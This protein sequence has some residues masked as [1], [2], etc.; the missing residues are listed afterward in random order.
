MG[1]ASSVSGYFGSGG[2]LVDTG[3]QSK[4]RLFGGVSFLLVCGHNARDGR[5]VFYTAVTR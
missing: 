5:T 3:V 4:V 2:L 1:N